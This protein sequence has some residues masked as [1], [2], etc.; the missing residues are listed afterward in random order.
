MRAVGLCRGGFGMLSGI[1]VSVVWL[2][3]SA[4]PW[5]ALAQDAEPTNDTFS[6]AA[7]LAVA[8]GEALVVR[9]SLTAADDDY[10]SVA[11]T[12]R[13]VLQVMATP[14]INDFSIPDTYAVLF[15]TDGTTEIETSDDAGDDFP[16]GD[17]YGFLF[18]FRAPA[19]GTYYFAVT[20]CCALA[21]HTE[22]GPY[23]LTVSVTI[24]TAA[25]D[26]DTDPG[27]D[28]PAGADDL[29]LE[30]GD[31]TLVIGELIAGTPGDVDFYAVELNAGEILSVFT[32]PLGGTFDDPDLELG[33]FELDGTAFV[34]NDDAGDDV[35]E[36]SELG[37][38]VRFRAP[39]T[40]TYYVG[41]SAHNDED[42]DIFNG[43]HTDSGAYA[44]TV[45]RLNIQV[46]AVP[47]A[48]TLALVALGLLLAGAG[49]LAVGRLRA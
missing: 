48:S 38:G 25:P 27:N 34:I 35:P 5:L 47:A 10:F 18:R 37:S 20:G 49:W 42:D 43:G 44:L 2:L 13:Q 41:V 45:S 40:G 17:E 7:S 12:E 11:L 4:A 1:R 28:T 39:T 30:A 32:T 3:L 23:A 21:N 33:V 8:E 22:D 29:V 46:L 26:L 6:G 31:A 15:D 19:A 36:G 16:E 24:E 9:G 14:L